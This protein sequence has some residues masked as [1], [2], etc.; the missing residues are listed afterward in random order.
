M[1]YNILTND[2][3]FTAWGW[4]VLT[5]EGTVLASG[6]IKTEP[7]HAK[8]RI[9]KSDDRVRRAGEIIRQLIKL[10]EKYNIGLILTELPHGS[11]NAQAAVMIGMVIGIVISIAES[12]RIPIECYSE[13]DSKKE[14]LGKRAATKNDM[15]DAISELYD[16]VHW[17]NIKYVDQAI[18][19]ALAIHYVASQQSQMIKILRNKNYV[20]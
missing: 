12:F 13:Q 1:T 2:P 16:T 20:R 15:V 19:D 10:I 6:C 11:Q 4:A 17:K 3:S 14:V 8:K 5:P 18:A 7:E 9:R